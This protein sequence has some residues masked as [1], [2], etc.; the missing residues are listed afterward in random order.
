MNRIVWRRLGKN[1]IVE[2][3]DIWCLGDPNTIYDQRK[4]G[5]HVYYE[6]THIQFVT[7]EMIGLKSRKAYNN[8]IWRAEEI[9][10]ATKM[11]K[12][13]YQDNEKHRRIDLTL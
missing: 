5:S 6:D 1:E 13:V 7:G 2:R 12:P 3:G 10:I 8:G 9:H 11:P 4:I